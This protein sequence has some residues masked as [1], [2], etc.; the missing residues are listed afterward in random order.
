MKVLTSSPLRQL[1]A[2]KIEVVKG[3]TNNLSEKLA[4]PRRFLR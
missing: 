1:M 4:F 2:V 3:G